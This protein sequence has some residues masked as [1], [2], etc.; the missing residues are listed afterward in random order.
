MNNKEKER[1]FEE[2]DSIHFEEADREKVFEKID[3]QKRKQKRS[4][5]FSFLK[6]LFMATTLGIVAAM[7]VLSFLPPIN[8][9]QNQ[10][11]IPTEPPEE[12]VPEST[13]VPD[14]PEPDP[15]TMG[16][17]VISHNDEYTGV[18]FAPITV[19][20]TYGEHSG[21]IKLALVPANLSL[22][23]YDRYSNPIN[24][25]EA[26]KAY[27]SK[28]GM[29]GMQRTYEKLVGRPIDFVYEM[30]LGTF[31]DAVE[32]VGIDSFAFDDDRVLDTRL[33][34]SSY[35]FYE[36]SEKRSIGGYIFSMLT[37]NTLSGLEGNYRDEV[38]EQQYQLLYVLFDLIFLDP[39]N[40]NMTDQVK[41]IRDLDPVVLTELIVE[42]GT[43]LRFHMLS[44]DGEDF[45]KEQFKE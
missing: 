39:T 21:T 26:Y 19:L 10:A 16:I 41:G 40:L 20:F 45:L 14:E 31:L 44:K 15:T 6:P 33:L 22:P 23:A 9:L 37:A 38:V 24:I 4:S 43:E 28:N 17:L 12:L 34:P 7:L 32:V 29:D 25:T 18:S 11:I 36:F 5:Y 35:S 30:E 27:S 3:E 1:V 8:L 42:H 2:F 13:I